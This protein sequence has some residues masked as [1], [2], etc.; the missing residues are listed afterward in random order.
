MTTW[1]RSSFDHH[2]NKI[3]TKALTIHPIISPH[4]LCCNDNHSVHPIIGI[5]SNPKVWISDDIRIALVIKLSQPDHVIGEKFEHIPMIL[6]NIFLKHHFYLLAIVRIFG[7]CVVGIIYDSV[8]DRW[9]KEILCSD[10]LTGFLK[11]LVVV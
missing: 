10:A 3:S 1:W 2:R 6:V 4:R 5:L 11:H 7:V 9:R 8:Y